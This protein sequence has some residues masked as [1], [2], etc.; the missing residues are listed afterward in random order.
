[1][2]FSSFLLS[3]LHYFLFRGKCQATIRI[4]DNGYMV[5]SG[6]ILRF[7][8]EKYTRIGI[9]RVF[10]LYCICSLWWIFAFSFLFCVWKGVTG[11]ASKAIKR[12]WMDGIGMA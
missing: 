4:R 8:D 6:Y 12:T 3:F 5:W 11:A 1:M 2:V 9:G 10:G 7:L